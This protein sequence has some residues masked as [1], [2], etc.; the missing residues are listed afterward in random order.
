VAERSTE[1]GHEWKQGKAVA[2]GRECRQKIGHAAQKISVAVARGLFVSLAVVAS[3]SAQSGTTALTVETILERMAQARAENRARFRSYVVTRNYTLFGKERDKSKAEVTAKVTFV[4]PNSKQFSIQQGT[5]SGLGERLVRR[6]LEGETDIVE[7]YGSTDISLDN[8]DFRFAGEKMLNNQRCY[9]LELL[10][11]RKNRALLRGSVWVDVD[12]YLL[13]RL[14]GEPAKSPSW[15][16]RNVRI[17]FT[18][19][20]VAGM[21]LQTASEYTTN[22]RIFG[23]YTMTSRDLGYETVDPMNGPRTLPHS[24]HPKQHDCPAP[25]VPVALEHIQPG[26]GEYPRGTK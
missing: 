16:L 26:G 1:L 13:H 4:P 9:V 24:N 25:C 17:A 3:A 11:K 18:Y 21:W 8:Y 12:S 14:E 22:V 19:S 15:W 2:T 20:D 23:H 10:P 6:M 7:D 5:G